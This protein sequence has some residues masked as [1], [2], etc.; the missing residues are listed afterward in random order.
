MTRRRA[1]LAALAIPALLALSA[2]DAGSQIVVRP[3][4]S[5]TFSTVLTVAGSAAGDALYQSVAKAEAQSTVPLTV[6]QYSSGT[7]SGAKISVPFRSLPD[8]TALGTSLGS[9]TGLAGVAVTK[10]ASGWTFVAHSDEGL[11][12]P[13]GSAPGAPG[14]SI[15]ASPM[16]GLV[17][18]SVAVE[19]PGAPGKTNASTATRSATT[20]RFVWTLAAGRAATDLRAAT[21]F[22]G[23]Q[24][25]AALATELTAL[26]TSSTAPPAAVRK[27]HDR[28]GISGAGIA[29]AAAAVLLA[30]AFGLLWRRRRS[31]SPVA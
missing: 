15:D 10:A 9:S 6:S 7:E 26:K 22:V 4:G 17:H 11:V 27:S 29:I 8:L 3:D 18:M 31:R 19:L 21:T 23:D 16:A 30:V 24:R 5:G 28:S 14:G 2:C 25:S 13:P 20:T 1:A 12:R